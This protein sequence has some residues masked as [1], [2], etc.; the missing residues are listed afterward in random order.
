MNR[1][2]V[3]PLHHDE[4][5]LSTTIAPSSSSVQANP[6]LVDNFPHMFK[7]EAILSQI[8]NNFCIMFTFGLAYPPLLIAVLGT[9]IVTYAMWKLILGRFLYHKVGDVK[10]NNSESTAVSHESLACLMKQ[11]IYLQHIEKS[12]CGVESAFEM[13]KVPVIFCSSVVISFLLYDMVANDSS[14]PYGADT[15]L[16]MVTLSMPIMVKLVA[17]A[18]AAMKKNE[19]NV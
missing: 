11:D 13:V 6:P 14:S 19:L 16:P 4:R 15:V 3:N 2:S 9:S 18:F 5:K 1:I 17:Q 7:P 12:L 8:V 10:S